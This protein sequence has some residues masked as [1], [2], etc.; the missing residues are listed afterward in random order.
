MPKPDEKRS[1]EH[2]AS[3]LFF[4]TS[5]KGSTQRGTGSA[6]NRKKRK[7]YIRDAAWT[8]QVQDF[9]RNSESVLSTMW[10]LHQ[11]FSD[12]NAFRNR[13]TSYDEKTKN[14]NN[15]WRP[16]VNLSLTLQVDKMLKY[17]N[18]PVMD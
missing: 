11:I 6:L 1:E 7:Y 15:S 10:K 5:T 3:F 4:I 16:F 12:E 18:Y 17:S 13:T 9:S 14:K 8:R 2:D